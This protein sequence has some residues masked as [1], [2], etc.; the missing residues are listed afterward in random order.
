MLTIHSS[1]AL[2]NDQQLLLQVALTKRLQ[3]LAC[4][5]CYCYAFV[6]HHNKHATTFAGRA[7][8]NAAIILRVF[9]GPRCIFLQSFCLDVFTYV[10]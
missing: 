5:L 3:N 4:K 8:T 9:P 6:L 1:N 2:H 10:N 7:N